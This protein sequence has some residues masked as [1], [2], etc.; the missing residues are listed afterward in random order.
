MNFD[1]W[2]YENKIIDWETHFSDDKTA[3]RYLEN[4]R[5]E[6]Y[7]F[8]IFCNSNKTAR[9]R[10]KYLRIQCWNC[11]KAFSVTTGTIFYHSRVKLCIWFKLLWLNFYYLDYLDS[12]LTDIQRYF[13]KHNSNTYHKEFKNSI[14]KQTLRKMINILKKVKTMDDLYFLQ[15]IVFGFTNEKLAIAK[16]E[17]DLLYRNWEKTRKIGLEKTSIYEYENYSWFDD[18][19]EN[20]NLRRFK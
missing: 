20:S 16:D 4:I 7:Y 9:H 12:K 14:S 11:H 5:W 19:L 1:S 2:Q 8:C 6:G 18:W 10:G 17:R 15:K 3:L 13:T